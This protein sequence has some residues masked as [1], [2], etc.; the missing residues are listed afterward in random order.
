MLYR[1]LNLYEAHKRL[2]FCIIVAFLISVRV[3]AFGKIPGGFNQDGAMGAVDALAL[4]QYGT[5][6]FGTWLPAHFWAWGNSQMSVLLSYLM[7]PFIWLGGLNA[8]TARLPMLIVSVLGALAVY[9]IVRVLLS[10]KAAL[11]VLVCVAINPWHFMQSRW[12]ID[13]NVFP[14]MFLLGTYFLIRGFQK[15]RYYYIS[16]IFYALC[17]YSYGVAFYMV[18]VFLFFACCMLLWE[19]RLLWYQ[20]AG[21]ALIYFGLS[22]PIYG[23][24]LINF[25]Q[26]D[27]VKLPFTT[28]QYFT[29][30]S[31]ATDMLLFSD[32]FW[33]QL[34]TNVRALVSIVFWRQTDSL[35][36]N[37]IDGYGT[38]YLCTMPL[39]LAGLGICIYQALKGAASDHRRIWRILL[40]YWVCSLL[41]GVCINSVNI[42]RINIIFYSHIMFAGIA[43]YF[44]IRKW[45]ITAAAL[46]VLYGILFG[47][48]LYTYFTQWADEIS[49][50]FYEN[51]LDAVAYAGELECD[52]YYITP[53]TRYEGEVQISEILTQFAL[54]MDARYYQGETDTFRGN[55]IAYAD[56]YHFSN[57]SAEE[58]RT[59]LD[60]A[61]VVKTALAEEFDSD[62]F[63]ITYF[64]DYCVVVPNQ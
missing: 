60:V 7:V 29:Y 53:D 25:L 10:D 50:R 37:A 43:V 18:P 38:M 41:V 44:L 30:S 11:I 45:R 32:D 4:S 3:I 64:D 59:D 49:D 23:T 31:R 21:C 17:M 16:M 35:A 47:C 2:W 36:W 39:V 33:G 20:A 13:C 58:I 27:T 48:F 8:V 19:K 34:I 42:N 9:G 40:L 24:M 28:M 12:A 57:P 5:D 62:C 26:L 15:S 54:Q 52:Y 56:R 1:L 14:H 61:Y 55:E 6:R 51:F 22:F 46:T 63:T